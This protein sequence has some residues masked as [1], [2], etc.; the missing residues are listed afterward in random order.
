MHFSLEISFILTD[1]SAVGLGYF[2][3]HLLVLGHP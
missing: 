2:T 3:L 1:Q